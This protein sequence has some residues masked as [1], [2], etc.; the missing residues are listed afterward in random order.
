M[1]AQLTP[2]VCPGLK[3]RAAEQEVAALTAIVEELE[4][5]AEGRAGAFQG[6]VQA[7]LSGSQRDHPLGLGRRYFRTDL[8]DVALR[9]RDPRGEAFRAQI[10]GEVM[11]RRQHQD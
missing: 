2:A 11:H 5:R 7:P 8:R 9:A 4:R 1:H 3:L 6:A 10:S